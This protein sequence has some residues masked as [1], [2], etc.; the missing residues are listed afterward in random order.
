MSHIAQLVRQGIS[1]MA[2]AEGYYWVRE[3]NEGN[4]I[5]AKFEGGEWTFGD[6]E[7][8]SDE[9]RFTVA[10]G[11]LQP[12]SPEV[13]ATW[14][15]RYDK[16]LKSEQG[17]G[18]VSGSGYDFIDGFYWIKPHGGTKPVLAQYME[19]WG[20]AA[21]EEEFAD[22]VDVLDGPLSPPNLAP[23]HKA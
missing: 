12:P 5:I 18:R 1:Q 22:E 3:R 8:Y 21:G 17:R 14:K 4:P 6:G 11:P 19:G 7:Y 20:E 23:S 9:S 16:L 15:Q 10:S 13:I 2:R